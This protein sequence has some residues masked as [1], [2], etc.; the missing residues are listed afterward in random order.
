MLGINDY[1]GFVAATLVFLMLPGPGTFGVLTSTGKGGLRAGFAALAGIIV[2]D[3][4]L[5]LLAVIGV[6]ALLQA[7]PLAFHLVQYAGAGY[8]VYLGVRL[9]IAKD[10]E[11]AP[12]LL[13][14]GN[15]KFFRQLF[16]ITLM[17]PK[18]IVFYMA[19]FPLF[20]DPSVHRG[21]LTFAAMA[22]TISI[23]TVLYGGM[24]V[25]SGN[26]LARRFARSDRLTRWAS[27]CAGLFLVGFGIRLS[28]Q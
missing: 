21:A 13:R 17:N 24:L 18:A 20:I 1:W 7:N 10:G 9:V 6:A 4:I 3:W 22:G 19:F 25:I 12:K 15:G 11:T 2:G 14:I 5:M 23:C 16:L 8:L 26:A 27:R 28:T